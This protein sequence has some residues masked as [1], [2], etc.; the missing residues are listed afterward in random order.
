MIVLQIIKKIKVIIPPGVQN[1]GIKGAQDLRLK[2]NKIFK[3]IYILKPNFS[4]KFQDQFRKKKAPP[5]HPKEC[6]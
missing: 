6:F 2:T 3:D 5:H 1:F 4:R